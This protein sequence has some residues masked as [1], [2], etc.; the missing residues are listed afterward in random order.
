MS[1]AELREVMER[2][3]DAWTEVLAANPDP[4]EMLVVHRDDGTAYE[5]SRGIRLAQVCTTAR[6]IGARSARRSRRSASSRHSSTPGTT[7][8]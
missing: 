1:L 8:R 6:T 5:A 3:G 7:A 4:S 2:H